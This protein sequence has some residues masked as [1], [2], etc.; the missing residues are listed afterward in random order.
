M[1]GFRIVTRSLSTVLR[2]QLKRSA[3]ISFQS[4]REKIFSPVLRK[5]SYTTLERGTPNTLGYR[6]FYGM[7][8]KKKKLLIY[9]TVFSIDPVYLSAFTPLSVI[10]HCVITILVDKVLIFHNTMIFFLP[11]RVMKN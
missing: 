4:Q 6:I 2:K 7:Y 5:M 3:V 10:L 9:M 8:L 1:I 11:R